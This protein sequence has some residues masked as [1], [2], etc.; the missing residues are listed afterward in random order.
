MS[1]R[2]LELFRLQPKLYIEGSPVFIE[3]GV[4]L[5]D[6]KTN[7]ITT[8]IKIRNLGEKRIIACKISIR[9]FEPNGD[10]V[11]G[12][13]TY[14]YLDISVN[15]GLAFGARVPISLPDI[16]TRMITVSVTEVVFI[17]GT[18]WSH[19]PCEWKQ[20]PEQETIND[21]FAD[22]EMQK[23][24][25]LEVGTDGE[26]VPVIDG[27]LFLC[28]CGT[29][30]ISTSAHCY[31]CR[32][33]FDSLVK[34]I[35]FEYLTAR[36]DV[37]LQKESEELD[38]LERKR[39]EAEEKAR[40]AFELRKTKTKKIIKI[41][42]PIVAVIALVIA[43]IP[44]VIKP[45]IEKLSAYRKADSLA[46]SKDYQSAIDIWTSLG[47]FSDS[48]ER[49]RM[50]EEDWKE[51]DYQIALKLIEDGQFDEASEAFRAL[52]D[53]KDASSMALE[54]QYQK[55]HSLATSQDYQ[56]AIEIW[57]SLGDYSD[58]LERAKLAE[59]DWKEG[60]YQVALSL[61]KEENYIEAARAFRE[62]AGYKDSEKKAGECIEFKKKADY[63]TAVIA[64]EKGD[65]K[66]AIEY[67]DYARGYED[68]RDRKTDAIY[69][70]ACQLLKDNQYFSAVLQFEKCSGYKDTASKILDAKYGYVVN[71]K[72]HKD[73]WTHSFLIDLLSV[74]YSGA[75]T[76]Y[77]E[78]YRWKLTVLAVNNSS[79]STVNMSSV[80]RH[81]RIYFHYK[82]AG[83]PPGGSMKLTWVGKL[84]NASSNRDYQTVSDGD[85]SW[86]AIWYTS[87]GTSGIAR[88]TFYDEDGNKLG[89][90]S[91]RLY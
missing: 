30:N 86:F 45:S 9:A 88:A 67:F 37:R 11:E 29:I 47:D 59:T 51:S 49:I 89:T 48:R 76:L 70:Y 68:A 87:G 39:K 19:A 91:I 31:K 4:L 42:I 46:A 71:N 72:S 83:G 63:H 58:S 23:Q 60:N 43:L 44:T 81:D 79:L 26:Y 40:I 61:M 84:P 62:L 57:M 18:V 54:A 16:T 3:A 53:Y 82:V 65:Y 28:T 80:S 78:L 74:N 15:Q 73:S 64:I 69:N 41:G 1:N 38:A 22:P 17:D 55:A 35:D 24:Y 12:I 2:L 52:R 56:S 66:T 36:K 6:T 77:K 8:Q 14:S 33:I 5:K 27:G 34:I 20:I 32:R 50:V 90:A 21:L 75:K 10:E 25:K 85:I 13:P 7:R